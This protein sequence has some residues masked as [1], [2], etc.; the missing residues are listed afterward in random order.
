MRRE[1]GRRYRA[2][3]GDVVDCARIGVH[4]FDASPGTGATVARGCPCRRGSLASPAMIILRSA[5]VV[6][7]AGVSNVVTS[8]H[9]LRSAVDAAARPC[10]TRSMTK[11]REDVPDDIRAMARAMLARRARE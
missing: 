1:R 7:G 5:L 3:V 6:K 2:G 10:D 11:P 9:V 8:S 4:S